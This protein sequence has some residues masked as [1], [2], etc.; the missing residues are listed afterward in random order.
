[1]FGHVTQKGPILKAYGRA[2]SGRILDEYL[3][4]GPKTKL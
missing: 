4:K 2:I 3:S 1:M